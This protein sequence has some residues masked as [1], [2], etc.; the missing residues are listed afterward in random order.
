MSQVSILACRSLSLA[1]GE[2]P[3]W[4]KK[5]DVGDVDRD[6]L[7]TTPVIGVFRLNEVNEVFGSPGP[8]VDWRQR[9]ESNA[10]WVEGEAA[11][12]RTHRHISTQPNLP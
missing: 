2:G 1:F 12:P 4:E 6:R 5:T 3:S 9:A 7:G 10:G 8:T 11:V